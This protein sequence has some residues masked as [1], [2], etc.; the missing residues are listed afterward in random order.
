MRSVGLSV[1]MGVRK[2]CERNVNIGY[3]LLAKL[4]QT[5]IFFHT[6]INHGGVTTKFLV[7]SS[8]FK[9]LYSQEIMS[10]LN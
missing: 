8:I 1:T 6:G 4:L 9:L 10:G 2:I 5:K 7:K 3:L